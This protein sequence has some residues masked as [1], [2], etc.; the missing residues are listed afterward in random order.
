LTKR[1]VYS[2][3]KNEFHWLLIDPITFNW[4]EWGGGPLFSKSIAYEKLRKYSMRYI[5][6]NISLVF[7]MRYFSRTGD[8]FC[9]LKEVKSEQIY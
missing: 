5:Y 1:L 2:P 9:I 8:Q 7:C 3:S 4:S 6:Y